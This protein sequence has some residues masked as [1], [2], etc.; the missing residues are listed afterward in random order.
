[1]VV[2]GATGYAASDFAL[3]ALQAVGTVELDG[4]AIHPGAG[5]VLGRVD[6][7][8]VILLPGTPLACLCAYDVLAS[9]LLRRMAG[10]EA[11]PGYPVVRLRIDASA[12]PALAARSEVRW[13]DRWTPPVAQMDQIREI[14]GATFASVSGFNGEGIV[15]RLREIQK[16]TGDGPGAEAR[17]AFSTAAFCRT[18]AA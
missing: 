4:V 12:L 5:I 18:E 16:F 15:G 3:A 7:T 1:M 9:R 6:A 10:G 2:A 14:T 8:P 17:V 13:I 11:D